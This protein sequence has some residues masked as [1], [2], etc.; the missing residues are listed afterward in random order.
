[1]PPL[2]ACAFDAALN[3]AAGYV[4]DGMWSIAVA[5]GLKVSILG[6]LN[7]SAPLVQF[8]PSLVE[9]AGVTLDKYPVEKV[10][11]RIARKAKKGVRYAQREVA[12]AEATA[13]AVKNVSHGL[14]AF[15]L[16]VDMVSCGS[17]R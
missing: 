1:M 6:R 11:Q 8:E 15:G 7:N 9:G 4:T 17:S 12:A 2:V 10:S 14:T 16:I 3:T 5:A 13:Q